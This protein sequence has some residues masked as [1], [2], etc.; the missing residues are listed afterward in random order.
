MITT[1]EI[2]LTADTIKNFA[3]NEDNPQNETI[4]VCDPPTEMRMFGGYWIHHD[5]TISF[6]TSDGRNRTKIEQL[7]GQMRVLSPGQDLDTSLFKKATD[8]Q[9]ATLLG[10]ALA[11]YAR[12]ICVSDE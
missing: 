5:T 6:L 3:G 11:G 2:P 4:I 1:V 8:E 9:W 10:L 7:A 12:C